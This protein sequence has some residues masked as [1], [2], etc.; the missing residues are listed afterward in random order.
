MFRHPRCDMKMSNQET[1]KQTKSNVTLYI[2]KKVKLERAQGGCLGTESR[3]R[4]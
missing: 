1:N 2:V 3:R 4:T